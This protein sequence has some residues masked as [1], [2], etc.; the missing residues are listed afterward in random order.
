MGLVQVRTLL[1][2]PWI[3]TRFKTT[4]KSYSCGCHQDLIYIFIFG[5]MDFYYLFAWGGCFWPL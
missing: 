3:R 4:G 2:N 1:N 5:N